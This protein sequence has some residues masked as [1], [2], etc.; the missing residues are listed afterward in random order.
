MYFYI[1]K[2]CFIKLFCKSIGYQKYVSIKIR[3]SELYLI[4]IPPSLSDVSGPG[5]NHDRRPR[6]TDQT[7]HDTSHER[8]SGFCTKSWPSCFLNEHRKGT[9]TSCDMLC[10]HFTATGVHL[11]RVSPACLVTLAACP[12]LQ[13]CDSV[14]DFSLR[15]PTPWRLQFYVPG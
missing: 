10:M 3:Y 8:R 7:C 4:S 12:S 13:M 6:M 1:Q 11:T 5:M 14:C 15:I 2:T 9:G